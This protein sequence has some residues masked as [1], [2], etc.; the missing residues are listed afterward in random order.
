[1]SLHDK[2]GCNGHFDQFSKT[3]GVKNENNSLYVNSVNSMVPVVVNNDNYLNSSG[4][5]NLSNFIL[6]NVCHDIHALDTVSHV[7]LTAFSSSALV[8]DSHKAFDS[9]R[10][11]APQHD[12]PLGSMIEPMEANL[13][14]FLRNHCVNLYHGSVHK[15]D[16]FNY[17]FVN[18]LDN[19][20]NQFLYIHNYPQNKPGGFYFLKFSYQTG[21]ITILECLS[22]RVDALQVCD[23]IWLYIYPTISE[24]SIVHTK[25]ESKLTY[26]NYKQDSLIK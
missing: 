17:T 13:Q 19:S 15:I 1:M 5:G 18:Q 7:N 10:N 20:H 12:S 4:G 25:R 26:D 14:P 16:R 21:Q 2:Q 9:N 22:H 24:L 23:S 11:L 3:I 6:Q 8:M